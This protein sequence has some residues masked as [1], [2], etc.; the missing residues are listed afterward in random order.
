MLMWHCADQWKICW[1]SLQQQPLSSLCT[2]AQLCMSHNVCPHLEE[3]QPLFLF[4][5]WWLYRVIPYSVPRAMHCTRSLH[6]ALSSDRKE[7]THFCGGLRNRVRMVQ[8]ISEWNNISSAVVVERGRNTLALN[9][10][11]GF[12]VLVAGC[13]EQPSKM[14]AYQPVMVWSL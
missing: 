13:C 4:R 3:W 12:E 7:V 9:V 14:C 10:L 1:E 2:I 8:L 5:F 6:S 11:S